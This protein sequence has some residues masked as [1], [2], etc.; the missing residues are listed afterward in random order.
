ML[1]T[2]LSV[3]AAELIT[4]GTFDTGL[5]SWTASGVV[6]RSSTSTL[7]VQAA[8]IS[9]DSAIFNYGDLGGDATLLQTITTVVGHSY[10]LQFRHAYNAADHGQK[11]RVQ[12]AGSSIIRDETVLND[13]PYDAPKTVVFIFVAT[14][15]LTTITFRDDLDFTPGPCCGSGSDILLDDVSVTDSSTATSAPIDFNFSKQ[16]DTFAIEIEMK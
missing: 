8:A 7:P 13:A 2:S 15:T 9:G 10:K 1:G 5:A 6:G 16:P 12:I 11:L 3:S 14:S 4:N